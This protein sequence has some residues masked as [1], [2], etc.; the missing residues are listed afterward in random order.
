MRLLVAV[1]SPPFHLR[2]FVEK[3]DK[4]NSRLAFYKE[5]DLEEVGDLEQLVSTQLINKLILFQDDEVLE[6]LRP[7]IEELFRPQGMN[8]DNLA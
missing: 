1:F 6:E 2:I 4:H 3:I 7:Q 5:P 8:F